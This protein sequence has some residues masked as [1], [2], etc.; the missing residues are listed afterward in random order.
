MIYLDGKPVVEFLYVTDSCSVCKTAAAAFNKYVKKMCGGAV[1]PRGETDKRSE[2]GEIVFCVNKSAPDDLAETHFDGKNLSFGGG[3]RGIIYAVYTFLEEYAG[4]RFFAQDCEIVPQKDVYINPFSYSHLPKISFRMYLGNAAQSDEFSLKRKFNGMLWNTHK[5]GEAEGGGYDFA[6]EPVHTLTG[7]YLLK[8][9][10]ASKPEFFSLV[11][12]KR[13][14]DR[15]GQV[16]MT[17]P[18][19]LN[20]V[21]Y[22]ARKLLDEHKDKNIISI[23]QGD[24]GNFCECERCKAETERQ[25]FVKTYFS[26]VNGVSRELKKSHPHVKVHTLAYQKTIDIPSDLQ[27]ESNV[28]L[29]YCTG[30]WCRTHAITDSCCE[31]NKKM[32][33]SYERIADGKRYIYV[34]DYL[35][36]FKYELLLLPDFFNL[37]YNFKYLADSG[38]KGLFLEAEH[39]SSDGYAAMHELRCYLASLAAW[40]VDIPQET[41]IRRMKEFIQV[42]Y[43]SENIYKVLELYTD[44][45]S[46]GHC[47]Y[48]AEAFAKPIDNTVFANARGRVAAPLIKNER[49]ESAMR[50]I[51][52]LL[53][54]AYK[55]ADEVQKTRID[56]VYACM[57]WYELYH[58]MSEILVHGTPQQKEEAYR[59]NRRLVRYIVEYRLKLTFWGRGIDDQ[60]IQMKKE[61]YEKIPPDKWNYDW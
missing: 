8:P 61:N 30:G 42:Y 4:C 49:L 28:M 39:R 40:D 10:V 51:Y 13:I 16:C 19:A 27:F 60:L 12:G 55:T 9:Y 29:Q 2:K 38:V 34:W 33:A 24:N 15:K 36:G 52:A 25:G 48:D 32:K 35:N 37:P 1:L 57:L 58:T 46:F 7:E 44:E 47:S 43:G 23:S 45:C 5:F 54:E 18:E 3:K 31:Q 56:K 22:E 6:G 20:A 59:K 26:F 21:V 41:Y 50:R 17:N 11:G 14:T 53:D